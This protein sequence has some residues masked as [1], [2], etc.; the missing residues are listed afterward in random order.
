MEI[1]QHTIPDEQS[2]YLPLH[3][4]RNETST[5]TK[6]RVVFDASAKTSTNV[7]L[8]DV[9]LKGPSVQEDLV[10]I[11][12]RFRT[13]KYLL[14]ADIKKMYRQ[15][16]VSEDQRDFQRIL[17][18]KD[19]SR[20]LNVY[21]LKTV[22]YGVVTASYLATACLKKLSEEQSST[23]PEACQALS[24]DFYVDDFLDGA[25]SKKPH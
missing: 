9:L 21:L 20:P 3:A 4:V 6:L 18:R 19:P 17:W 11:V 5:S 13:H 15:I 8:N 22:T 25:M 12:T 10:S 7:S 14:T 23:F 16:W 1:T 24:R 2:Y